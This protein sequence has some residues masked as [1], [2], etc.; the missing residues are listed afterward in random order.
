MP[1]YDYISLN[2][3]ENNTNLIEYSEFS[4][5]IVVQYPTYNSS[6]PISNKEDTISMFGYTDEPQFGYEDIVYEE[7]GGE[8]IPD[9]I[10][11][12]F[13]RGA[14][15]LNPTKRLLR[16][17][18]ILLEDDLGGS[19]ELPIIAFFKDND[20]VVKDCKIIMG[21]FHPEKHQIL[22][23]DR[24]LIVI[25]VETTGNFV[26]GKVYYKLAPYRGK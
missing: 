6:T 18:G 24:T 22:Q 19:S 12:K 7:E 23:I 8:P 9:N 15:I 16:K 14:I 5:D 11:N 25:D 13:T 4:Q 2:I 17:L 10:K 3:S 1:V 20:Q 26:V 21:T